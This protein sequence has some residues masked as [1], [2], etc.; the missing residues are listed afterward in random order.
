MA[1]GS[2]A[3]VQTTPAVV[4]Q[5]LCNLLLQFP[6]AAIGGIRW[7]A[8]VKK[9]EERYAGRLDITAMGYSTPLSAATT[10]LWE[11]LRVVS[12]EDA[13]NPL[14]A[15]DDS[16]ALTPRPGLMGT[17]PSIY[18]TLCEVVQ[19]AD[20]PEEHC[21]KADSAASRGLLLAQ[22]KPL[23]QVNWDA[24]FDE[25]SMGYLSE[26]GALV[27]M[28]KMKHLVQAVL[29]WR[30]ERVEWR[31][32]SK[33]GAANGVDGALRQRLELVA[34]K[35]HNDFVLRFS[36]DYGEP[37]IIEASPSRNAPVAKALGDA[38]ARVSLKKTACVG[39]LLQQPAVAQQAQHPQ[40][41]VSREPTPTPSQSQMLRQL[42][43]S[44]QE[45][46]CRVSVPATELEL[47]LSILRAENAELRS[48]NEQLLFVQRSD[49]DIDGDRPFT[50]TPARKQ[51]DPDASCRDVD[52]T[53]VAP[54]LCSALSPEKEPHHGQ[55]QSRAQ[56]SLSSHS[57][58]TVPIFTAQQVQKSP[59]VQRSTEVFDD[60]YEPPPQRHILWPA[61]TAGSST[62][63]SSVRGFGMGNYFDSSSQ[64][65]S[66]QLSPRHATTPY[67]R[68]G[69]DLYS[70]HTSRSMTP[71]VIASGAMTPAMMGHTTSGSSFEVH[72]AANAAAELGNKM[73]ALVPVWFSYMPSMGEIMGDRGVIPTGIVHRFRAQFE[74]GADPDAPP[75]MPPGV[76]PAVPPADSS[77]MPL[78]ASGSGCAASG[79]AQGETH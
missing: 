34:S 58:S 68:A 18:Q 79:T 64:Q 23:L 44:K 16:A 8:L 41:D 15:V 21:S 9:Y 5:R 53:C 13:D 70:A 47:E 4:S 30:D 40:P 61:S 29:R 78:S 25:T 33:G 57:A 2:R 17:W 37:A 55:Q 59:H 52:M 27:K 11:V 12:T 7:R 35:R 51:T 39:Q 74:S 72:G 45:E 19:P 65:S 49:I 26:D 36:I 6:A 31:Q 63:A 14:L 43:L 73:C 22:L 76:V 77:A 67:W 10:L 69:V 50:S 46:E 32:R 1:G 28:K 71:V 54:S 42:L 60:P 24:N 20:A 66:A 75:P 3:H 38:P 62:A 56:C 48:R